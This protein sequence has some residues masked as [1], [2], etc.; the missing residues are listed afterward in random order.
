MN[1]ILRTVKYPTD[2]DDNDD[3]NEYDDD[4]KHDINVMW[5]SVI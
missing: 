5:L 3:D 4:V 2:D 1:N